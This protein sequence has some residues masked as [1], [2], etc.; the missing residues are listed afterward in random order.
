MRRSDPAWSS[1]NEKRNR[2]SFA[3]YFI[4]IEHFCKSFSADFVVE[5]SGKVEEQQN[6]EYT[7][8]CNAGISVQFDLS[9]GQRPCADTEWGELDDGHRS[10]RSCQTE[11][12][13]WGAAALKLAA[14]SRHLRSVTKHF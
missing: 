14:T 7:L 13:Q 9:G 10:G 4:A 8:V 12:P 3:A 6:E 1:E 2:S 11:A 5:F